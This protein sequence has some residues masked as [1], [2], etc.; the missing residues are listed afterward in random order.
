FGFHPD[1][2]ASAMSCQVDSR[3]PVDCSG[4]TLELAK[5]KEGGHTLTVTATDILGNVAPTTS[6]WTV[7][8]T[9]P[10]LQLLS[11]PPPS[12][13]QATI[14]P[15]VASDAGPA[16]PSNQASATF[17]FS[18][19]DPTATFACSLDGAEAV[20]CATPVTYD[21]LAEGGHSLVVTGTDPAGNGGT[22][23]AGWT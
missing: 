12:W 4:G 14:A 1:E 7:D 5:V 20:P 21:G 2:P 17:A 6:N 22:A 3:P 15:S 8:A 18:S 9:P 11:A 13:T 19:D 10:T 16:D 23:S